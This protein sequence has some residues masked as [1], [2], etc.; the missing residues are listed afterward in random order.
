[1]SDELFTGTEKQCCL[2]M[3]Q[4]YARQFEVCSRTN[5]QTIAL[6]AEKPHRE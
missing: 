4:N 6:L 2:W 3:P 1:M 5:L